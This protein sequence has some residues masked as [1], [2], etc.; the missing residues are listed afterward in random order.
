MH[1]SHKASL[2]MVSLEPAC[3]RLSKPHAIVAV[4]L[5]NSAL[6]RIQ[7]EDSC[8]TSADAVNATFA[9]NSRRIT[10]RQKGMTCY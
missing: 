6:L 4:K 7:F 9:G 8:W 5:R 3:Y 2:T 1:D 10:V